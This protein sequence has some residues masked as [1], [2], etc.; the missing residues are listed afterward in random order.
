M[1]RGFKES[2][3]GREEEMKDDVMLMLDGAQVKGVMMT[4]VLWGEG[5]GSV[6]AI[7]EEM[8]LRG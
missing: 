4:L 1:D 2:V 6:G 7:G 3:R 5:R 8:V